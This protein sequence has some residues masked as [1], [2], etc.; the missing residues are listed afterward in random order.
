VRSPRRLLVAAALLAVLPVAGCASSSSSA[1]DGPVANVTTNDDDGLN[2]ILLPKP[3]DAARVSL[4]DTAGKPYD[5]ATDPSKPLT[6]VFFGYTHCPD[7]CQVVMANIAAGLVRLDAAQ[8]AKVGMVFVTTDPRRDTTTVLR[9]YLDRFNP[10]FEGLTGPIASVVRAGKGF[11]V[12]IEKGQKLATGGYDV[13]HGTNVIGLRPD[14]TAPYV[15]TQSTTPGG[16]ADDITAILS[17]KVR[18]G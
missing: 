8:R 9:S 17:G 10:A 1:Q 6:L 4:E 5:L 15:W 14:G 2:G 13:T 16:L 12:P 3:Y 11:D 18:A 7:I